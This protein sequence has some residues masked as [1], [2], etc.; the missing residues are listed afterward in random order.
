MSGIFGKTTA[1]ADIGPDSHHSEM[2]THRQA[3]QAR[4]GGH[5]HYVGSTTQHIEM[6]NEDG[7]PAATQSIMTT[8]WRLAPAEPEAPAAE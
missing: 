2:E 8:K 4:L 7:S 6:F 1:F 3:A 5:V